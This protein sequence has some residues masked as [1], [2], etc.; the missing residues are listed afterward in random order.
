MKFI[1]FPLLGLIALIYL[2]I[3]SY[4]K[5][6][7]LKDWSNESS[8]SQLASFRYYSWIIVFIIALFGLLY[9]G[10]MGFFSN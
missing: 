7:H 1:I 4:K 9:K 2:L 3:I 6:W 8:L 5:R 10:V